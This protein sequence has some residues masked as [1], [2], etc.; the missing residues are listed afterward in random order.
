MMNIFDNRAE[1]MHLK[2]NTIVKV[3]YN[4]NTIIMHVYVLN[5]FSCFG[6][7]DLLSGHILK[8]NCFGLCLCG[9][10]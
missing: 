6:V 4:L 10:M 2:V 3:Y 7:G 8:Y 1:L 5:V 9:K